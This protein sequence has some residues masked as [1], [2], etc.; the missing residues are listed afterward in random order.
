VNGRH[1]A[2]QEEYLAYAANDTVK[3]GGNQIN[4]N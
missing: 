1:D 3:S 4:M 2:L